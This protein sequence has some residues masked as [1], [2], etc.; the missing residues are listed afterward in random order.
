MKYLLT[1]YFLSNSF[2]K[3]SSKSIRVGYVRVM[4]R[5]SSDIFGYAG[6]RSAVSSE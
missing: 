3:K 1:A 4:A 5:Q 6:F 2:A